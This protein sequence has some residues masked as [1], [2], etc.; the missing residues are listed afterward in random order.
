MKTT[1]QLL[2][3]VSAFALVAMSSAPA[4]AQGTSAG[5]TIRNEVT[6]SYNVG[7]V[8]QNAE[9]ATDEFTVD[10]RVNVNVNFVGNATTVNP[11]QDDA[12]IA[13][14]VTNLS[15]STVDL[16]LA[17]ALRNG[18]SANISNFRI[19]LDTDGDRTLSAAELQ[20]GPVTYLDEVGSAANG[21]TV[22]VIVLADIGLNAE[23][24]NTFDVTLTAN[25]HAG[26]TAGALGA[27]LVES[28]SNTVGID[29]VLFDGQGDTDAPRDGAFSDTGTYTVAGAVVTV[30][31]SSRVVSDPVNGSTNPKAIPG[32]TVEYCITVANASG[33]AT[34]TD[35]DVTDDLPFDV[36]FVDAS[37]FVDGDAACTN[38]TNGG[39]F[40][41]GAGANG[42]DR[43]AG[44]LSNVDGGQ[45][46]SLYFQVVID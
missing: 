44:D 30:A 13:F 43:V 37:I 24:T 1:K 10:Q 27:E 21:V 6:V 15:N 42:A 2:G 12:V 7:G 35:V 17:A 26:D 23:N 25:A 39:T 46:R 31:K 33:A 4:L 5:T 14:D 29:T 9:T 8:T 28:A 36:S 19:F 11:G 22:A 18:T 34:A 3:A 40:T 38:G 45:T 41:A 20:A 32:A 16:D